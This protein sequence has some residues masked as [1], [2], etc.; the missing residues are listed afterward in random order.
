M[1]TIVTII[2]EGFADWETAILNS[3]AR[4]YYGRAVRY[5]SP[6]GKTVTSTGGLSVTPDLAVEA[7]DID[8]IDAL[9]VCGGTGWQSDNPPDVS[10]TVKA[11]R[12]KGKLIGAICDGTIVLAKAGLLDTAA[13]TSNGAGYLDFTGYGGKAHYR[14]QPQAVRDGML[15]TASGT[16]PVS[17]ASAVLHALGMGDENLDY[18][19][20]LHAAQFAKAA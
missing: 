20:N 5:A 19:I 14:D 18:Y 11:A 7:I 13:H 6:G 12:A 4:T 16:S 9:I 1:T 3:C 15:I 10:A 17:F 2:A 8:A